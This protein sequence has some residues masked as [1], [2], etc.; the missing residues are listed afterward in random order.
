MIELN[1]KGNLE[2]Q[3][4]EPRRLSTPG[5]VDSWYEGKDIG[6][7]VLYVRDGKAS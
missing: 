1:L 5:M 3:K 4:L 2:F 6:D 7:G